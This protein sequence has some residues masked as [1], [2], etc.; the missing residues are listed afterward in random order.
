MELNVMKN[1]IILIAGMCGTGKTSFAEYL[2]KKLHIPLV[3]YDNIKSKDWEINNKDE[4]LKELKLFGKFS[5]E[6]FWFFIEEIMKSGSPLIAE[7]FFHPQNL[8]FLNEIV[9]KYNY[10]SVT[11]ILDADIETAYNRFIKRNENQDRNEGLRIRVP[12]EAF[13]KCSEPNKSFRFGENNIVVN[14][15]DFNTINYDDIIKE[16]MNFIDIKSS[17]DIIN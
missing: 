1:T 4:K 5:Y 15:N 9:K 10:N 13:E 12:F 11:V 17:L 2:S 7:Y 8:L 6:Y 3:C 16:I 14:T